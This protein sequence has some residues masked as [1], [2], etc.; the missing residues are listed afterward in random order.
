MRSPF[1]L[2]ISINYTLYETV[3][4]FIDPKNLARILSFGYLLIFFFFVLFVGL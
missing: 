3:S 2:R 1:K 4:F